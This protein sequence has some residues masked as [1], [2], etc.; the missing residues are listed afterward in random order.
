[1]GGRRRQAG[2]MSSDK[3]ARQRLRRNEV[4]A[5]GSPTIYA[6]RGVVNGTADAHDHDFMEVALMLR[7]HGMHRT[8]R[9]VE[10]I[11]PGDI[12]ILRPGA[13]H[14]YEDCHDLEVF[15]CGFDAELLQHELAWLFED[16][17]LNFLLWSGPL[18]PKQNGLVTL[19]LGK[20]SLASCCA[21][22]EELEQT[23]HRPPSDPQIAGL[24]RLLLF[25]AD[26]AQAVD[27]HLPKCVAETARPHSAVLRGMRCLE[28]ELAREWTLDELA[29]TLR[30]NRSYLVRLFKAHTGLAPM[31][32]LARCR[33]E[34]A[35]TLLLRS[36]RPIAII[37]T[38]IGWP[39]PNYFARRFKQHLGMPASAYRLRFTS[40]RAT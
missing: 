27:A 38:E 1:M 39:D 36:T 23:V 40:A 22:L 3:P 17:R 13:W 4:F 25:F 34:R 20:K 12:F 16:Q 5:H 11:R 15:N 30:I 35:A 33:A 7:G 31:A 10:P 2:G 8:S 29:G 26:L 6:R 14:A 9:G 21:R 32:Y 37:A 28:T 18:A 19:H 24:G